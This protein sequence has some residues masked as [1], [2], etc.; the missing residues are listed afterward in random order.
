[1][2]PINCIAIARALNDDTLSRTITAGLPLGRGTS[3]NFLTLLCSTVAL[4]ACSVT[5]KA[6]HHSPD[7][8]RAPSVSGQLVS[9]PSLQP[10]VATVRHGNFLSVQSSSDITGNF[11]LPAAQS[12]EVKLLLPAAGQQ[13]Q[14]VLIEAEGYQD[15]V[16]WLSVLLSQQSQQKKQLYQGSIEQA[17]FIFLDTEPETVVESLSDFALPYAAIERPLLQCDKTAWQQ[18]LG[19]TNRARKLAALLDG[20][21]SVAQSMNGRQ[22]LMLMDSYQQM[23]TAWKLVWFSC[24]FDDD[25]SRMQAEALFLRLAREAMSMR[26]ALY[27]VDSV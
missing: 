13:F 18:A 19:L 15:T 4:C 22:Q 24:R 3:M 7:I 10:L 25:A 5:P 1:M 8:Y 9:L 2:K 6:Y 23:E 20:S 16:V 12:E 11:Q 26:E 14:P 27:L 21:M 17:G